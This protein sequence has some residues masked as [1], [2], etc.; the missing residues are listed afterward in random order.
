ML[1]QKDIDNL[2][3]KDK[4]YM[5]SV[6]E[7]KELYVRVNP[8]GKK[9][10]YLRAS[11]FKNFIT[12][13]ECQKGVLNVTNAREKAKDLLK[14]MYDGKFIG[15]NDKVMTLEKANFLYVDIKSKKLNSATIKKEQ[16]IFKKYI[17][18]TLGQ[19]DINELK[20]D[21]FLPIYDLMQK[22]GIYETINKNISLLCRIFEISRQRGDLKTDIIL[23]LKDL[24]KFYNEANHNKVKHFKA[25][26]EEQEIKNMLECMKEYKNHPRTNTTIINAIYFTLL[27]AQ[28]SK[29]IRFAKWS[30][31][32]FENNLWIIKANEM[33]VRTN[34]DNIIPLNKY[35]LKILDMQR[36]LNGDKKY[37]FANNNGTISE[38]FAVR[39]FKFYNL[40]HTIHGYRSTFRSVYTNKSN[41]LI[42]QGISKDIAEMILHHISGNEIERAYNRA[43]AIDLRVKL[44]QWYG[45]YLNSLCEF[46]F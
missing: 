46:C 27:T 37:I 11:K 9:V 25:I 2:E 41:E 39:F 14:S 36:I 18:P 12:I 13:G 34:G 5:I 21:D 35:A 42:Q 7:P 33:K 16:S 20:K 19:K 15:K 29:N 6:G 40:E 28:R 10:F 32:D 30:D 43:K 4:R 3:I 22:K 44:M 38:N 1:T 17:I 31:I 24:K 23:Q 8:T 45:N 26:V